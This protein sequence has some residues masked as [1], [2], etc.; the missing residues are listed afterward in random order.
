MGPTSPAHNLVIMLN[1]EKI[2]HLRFKSSSEEPEY[3]FHD[4][5]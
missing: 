3:I 1:I 5:N 4:D 2:Q